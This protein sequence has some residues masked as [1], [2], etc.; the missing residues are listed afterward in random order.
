M[1]RFELS[2]P[3]GYSALN[4]TTPHTNFSAEGGT[5]T[6]TGLLP[7]RPE[8]CVYSNFTTSAK[9]YGVNLPACPVIIAKAIITGFRHIPSTIQL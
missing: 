3:C 6:H 4:A 9:F 2:Q 5:R 7:Q 8:R 1:E